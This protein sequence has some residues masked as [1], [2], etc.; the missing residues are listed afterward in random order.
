MESVSC[1][2]GLGNITL[3]LCSAPIRL[4]LCIA[5]SF[6]HSGLYDQLGALMWG[7]VL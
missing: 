2:T 3:R 5:F 7:V 4:D 1:R 6:I